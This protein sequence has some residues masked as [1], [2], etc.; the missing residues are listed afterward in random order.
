[1]LLVALVVVGACLYPEF[2]WRTY[3]LLPVSLAA[4]YFLVG[5]Q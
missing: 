3:F 5:V 2:P 1:M 4:D